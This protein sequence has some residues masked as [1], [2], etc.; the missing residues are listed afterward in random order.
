[1]AVATCEARPV[2]LSHSDRGVQYR[3]CEHHNLLYDHGAKPSMRR[4]GHC[5]DN[6]A[7]ESLF[8]R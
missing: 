4:K 2:L 6:A 7:M 3:T 5:L 1:M 8:T